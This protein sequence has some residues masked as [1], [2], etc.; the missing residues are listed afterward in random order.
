VIAP[1]IWL[2]LT[3]TAPG[4]PTPD[5]MKGR[6]NSWLVLGARLKAGVTLAQARQSLDALA[7]R[8]A[9]EYPDAYQGRGLSAFPLS[10]VPG[11]IGSYAKIVLA[12]LMSLVGLVL[13]V[14]CAN[15]A[16]LMVA[17]SAS[18]SREIAVRLALGASRLR[19]V[20]TV[21]GE[22]L[23]VTAVG[24]AAGAAGARIAGGGMSSLL[25]GV[26]P[27][28]TAAF[29]AAIGALALAAAAA[30]IAPARQAARTDPQR[31]LR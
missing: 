12:V 7:A 8:L 27:T 19:I 31:L 3:S 4:L 14:A 22:G 2:P 9:A 13:I 29:V 11:E 28:D 16:G 24:L 18:R 17:R 10:R 23:A 15:L 25:V 21:V 26:A 20:R 6:Q 5:L 1:D 30:C